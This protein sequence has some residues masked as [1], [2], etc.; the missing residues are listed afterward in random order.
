MHFER[1]KLGT[2]CDVLKWLSVFMSHC[3]SEGCGLREEAET[4]TATGT[5]NGKAGVSRG[6][7][8]WKQDAD[9]GASQRGASDL[10]V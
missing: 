7:K 9:V 3:S 2:V 5:G 6:V 4:V 1:L 10:S 8:V